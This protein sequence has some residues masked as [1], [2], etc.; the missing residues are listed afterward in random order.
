M[1]ARRAPIR[2]WHALGTVRH[3]SKAGMAP[4]TAGAAGHVAGAFVFKTMSSGVVVVHS[5]RV[6]VWI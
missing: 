4:H 2:T 6:S 5:Q 1:G 3:R